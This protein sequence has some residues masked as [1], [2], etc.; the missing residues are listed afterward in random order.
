MKRFIFCL[1][2]VAAVCSAMAQPSRGMMPPPPQGT[3]EQASERSLAKRYEHVK[4]ALGM[5]DEQIEKFA[6]VYSAY[7]RDIRGIRKDLKTLMDSYKGE[8]IDEKT[9]FRLVM[10]QLNADADIIR[11]KK[12]YMRVFKNYLTPDQ[13]SKIFLIEN[14]PP[15]KPHGDRHGEHPVQPQSR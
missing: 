2:A 5:T 11:C 12:E 3:Q 4:N 7:Q 10:A 15:R 14:R 9:A 6:P 13:M 8:T 1:L